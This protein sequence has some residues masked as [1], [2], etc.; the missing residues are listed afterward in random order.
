MRLRRCNTECE[1]RARSIAANR[2]R[3]RS[4]A[5]AHCRSAAPRT[6]V[7]RPRLHSVQDRELACRTS[8]WQR[9]CRSVAAHRPRS[10]H[11]RR[12]G[13]A[14]CRCQRRNLTLA[15][16]KTSRSTCWIRAILRWKLTGKKLQVVSNLS[17]SSGNPKRH[18]IAWYGSGRRW[19]GP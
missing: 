19:S 1:G 2:D 16:S 18:K 6:A 17:S 14:L 12:R 11:C 4:T 7:A 10:R 9:R 3:E 8:V 13:L 15:I 5:Q